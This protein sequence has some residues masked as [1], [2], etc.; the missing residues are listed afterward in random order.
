MEKRESV[1]LLSL[2]SLYLLIVIVLW[3]FLTV[4]QIGLQCA[5]VEFPDHTHLPFLYK[6]V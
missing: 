3:L 2:S 6:N 1:A 4:P 5:I